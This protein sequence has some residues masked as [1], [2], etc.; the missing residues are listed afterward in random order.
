[1]IVGTFIICWLPMT[2]S[3]FL[4][5]VIDQKFTQDI[6]DVFTILSHFNSA[7]DPL[8]Y[9][10]RITDVRKTIKTLFMCLTLKSSSPIEPIGPMS[11]VRI[12]KD[13]EV[14]RF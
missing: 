11:S 7:I 4:Y 5:A 1:M 2:V 6:L 9:A 13:P 14:T 10:Y 8:I 12:S 3:Y